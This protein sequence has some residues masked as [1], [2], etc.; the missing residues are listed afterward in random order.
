MRI[1]KHIAGR[2]AIHIPSNIDMD[3]LIGWGVSD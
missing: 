1:V 3:D 2:M